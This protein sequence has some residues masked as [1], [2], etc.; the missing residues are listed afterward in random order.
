MKT[1]SIT[2][3]ETIWQYELDKFNV[4]ETEKVIQTNR[5]RE[6]LT[7]HT[8]EKLRAN[9]PPVSVFIP[10]SLEDYTNKTI[11]EKEQSISESRTVDHLATIAKQDPET[12]QRFAKVTTFPDHIK[13]MLATQVDAQ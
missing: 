4:T 9:L 10:L 7:A 8:P 2:I 11:A 12:I 5:Q 3:D 13:E 1:F 6:A